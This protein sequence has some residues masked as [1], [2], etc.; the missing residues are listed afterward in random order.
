MARIGLE[1][2]F[3]KQE[4]TISDSLVLSLHKTVEARSSFSPRHTALEN[5]ALKP[6]VQ[7]YCSGLTIFLLALWEKKDREEQIVVFKGRHEVVSSSTDSISG[8]VRKEKVSGL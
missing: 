8:Y 6:V 1:P 4:G 2:Y 7:V 5:W 3:T